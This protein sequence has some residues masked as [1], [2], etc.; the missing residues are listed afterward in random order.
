MRK[1]AFVLAALLAACFTLTGAEAAKKRV[2]KPSVQ[3]DPAY[4]WNLKNMGA[5]PMASPD[6]A[7]PA[8]KARKHRGSKK[9]AKKKS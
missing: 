4:E 2:A 1:F 5:P 9:M 7:A 3:A 8:K 6:G